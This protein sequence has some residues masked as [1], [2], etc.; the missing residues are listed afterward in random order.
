MLCCMAA[1][2]SSKKDD[3]LVKIINDSTEEIYGIGYT[4]YVNGEIVSSGGVCNADNSAFKN[5]ENFVLDNI[6]DTEEFELEL[7]VQDKNG[8][9]YPCDSKVTINE[10]NKQYVISIS[11]DFE[12][13]FKIKYTLVE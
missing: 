7:S 1:C 6:P 2:G 13:G 10:K 8:K 11:G 9:E 3:A 5:G 4:Y 12:N